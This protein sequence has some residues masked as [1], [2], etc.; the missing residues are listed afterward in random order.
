MIDYQNVFFIKQ[1]RKNSKK[2][3][4]LSENEYENEIDDN[5]NIIVEIKT[6]TVDP[7]AEG[8]RQN[9]LKIKS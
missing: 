2:T 9:K 3:K 7:I 5:I 6:T 4:K 8:I 1:E